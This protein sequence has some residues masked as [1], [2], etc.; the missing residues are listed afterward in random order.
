MNAF[1]YNLVNSVTLLSQHK[2]RI[3]LDLQD[4]IMNSYILYKVARFLVI[5][6]TNKQTNSVFFLV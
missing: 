2:L 6:D 1:K 4:F 3:L 5:F